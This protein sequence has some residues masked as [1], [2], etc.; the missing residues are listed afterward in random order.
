MVDTQLVTML[1]QGFQKMP[2]NQVGMGTVVQNEG[3]TGSDSEYQG[4]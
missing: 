3:W 4:W 1:Q 2:E